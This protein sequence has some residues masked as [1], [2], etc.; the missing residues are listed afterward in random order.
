MFP[1]CSLPPDEEDGGSFRAR[2]ISIYTPRGD[3]LLP[4]E[5]K[6][7]NPG[8]W[9]ITSGGWQPPFAAPHPQSPAYPPSIIV[10]QKLHLYGHRIARQ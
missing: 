2:S 1:L 6:K 9:A 4:S 5:G 8:G 10:T 3:F 7:N